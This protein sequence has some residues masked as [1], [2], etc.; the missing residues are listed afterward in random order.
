MNSPQKHVWFHR[1]TM[2][3]YLIASDV[4]FIEGDYELERFD[5]ITKSVS[6]S[7]LEEHTISQEEAEKALR[8]EYDAAMRIAR[9]KMKALAR[10]AD[11]SGKGANNEWKDFF[12]GDDV[13]PEFE[14]GQEFV[15]DFFKS[16]HDDKATD[17]ERQETFRETF[18]K[19]PEIMS[20]FD[21]EALN[22]AAEDPDAWADEIYEKMFGEVDKK[23]KEATKK[24]RQSDINMEI[25][26]NIEEAM[27]KKQS[28]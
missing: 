27:K 22:K 1:E 26:K 8:E 24:Q 28:D 3:Y 18:K 16:I 13:A 4:L 25:Q 17:K 19:V 23:R 2:T 7:G 10:F 11:L 20:F 9:T 6:D 21:E 15:Q 14:A 5:G 12:K